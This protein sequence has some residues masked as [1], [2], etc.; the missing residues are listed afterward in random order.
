[1][2]RTYWYRLVALEGGE[3]MVIG[4]PIAVQAGLSPAFRLLEVGPNPGGGPVVI[5][6]ALKHSAT[7]AIDVYD[8]QGRRVASPGRGSWPTGT[9]T[10]EWNGRTHQGETAP[11]GL[12]FLR[13]QFPG[14]Q[15]RR[16]IIRTR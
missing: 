13:Y 2:D 1:L 14:G 10:V 16:A 4:S 9:H 8:V 15:D 6:F 11:A 5:T 3:T 7:I 12:Y